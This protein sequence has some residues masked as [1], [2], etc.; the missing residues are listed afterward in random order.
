MTDSSQ[1]VGAAG[2]R[3]GSLADMVAVAGPETRERRLTVETWIK[4]AVLAVLFAAMYYWQFPYLVQSWLHDSNWSHAFAIPLFSIY[5]LYFRRD[6]LLSAKRRSCLWGLVILLLGIAISL[7]GVYPIQNRW[8]SNLGMIIALFGLVFYVAGPRVI[9]V[10][11]LPIVYL[12]L[13]MPVSP[14]I[15][16]AVAY[17]L[18]EFAA[19]VSVQLMRL[20]GV[21]LTRTASAITVTTISGREETLTVAEACSGVRSLMAFVALAVAWAYI[22][23]RPAWQRT[24]LVLAAVPVAI[25][26]NVLRVTITSSMFVIDHRELGEDFMHTF[27]GMLMLIPAGIMLWLLSKL[28]QSI[29]VEHEEDEAEESSDSDSVEGAGA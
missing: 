4:T 23:D 6:D 15:Y 20:F 25:L 14:R 26:C 17:Q 13:A 8:S 27:L 10:T 9:R 18:Q 2:R 1:Q 3:A 28:L 24:V 21:E 16:T 7:L 29:Y 5:L 12:A 22:V 19:M 11:W